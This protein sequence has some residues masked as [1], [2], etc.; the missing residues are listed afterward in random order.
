[1]PETREG[2][3][4]C[5]VYTDAAMTWLGAALY[6]VHIGNHVERAPRFDELPQRLQNKWREDAREWL[7]ALIPTLEVRDA[8]R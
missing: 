3:R 8:A 7:L 2:R 4:P 1:M 5:I 6:S